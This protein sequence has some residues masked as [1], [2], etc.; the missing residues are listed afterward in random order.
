MIGGPV[1]STGPREELEGLGLEQTPGRPMV[2]LAFGGR[3]SLLSVCEGSSSVFGSMMVISAIWHLIEF[4][5]TFEKIFLKF[6]CIVLKTAA[7]SS[8]GHVM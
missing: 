6:Q 8:V 5:L 2:L 4:F 1:V 3:Y 7:S